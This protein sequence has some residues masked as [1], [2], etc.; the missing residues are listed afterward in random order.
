VLATG[1]VGGMTM[2]RATA[3]LR[4]SKM[5]SR[6]LISAIVSAVALGILLS[7][8]VVMSAKFSWKGYRACSTKSP[9]FSVSAVPSGTVQLMFK[10]VDKDVPTYP[11]GGG[12][13]MFTFNSEIPAGA[14][15]RSVPTERA[16]PY[17]RMDG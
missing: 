1:R 17:L 14:F 5:L 11:H 9:A 2:Q 13:V 6:V 7:D 15:K 10:M 8:A 3:N 4:E 16:T 12:L